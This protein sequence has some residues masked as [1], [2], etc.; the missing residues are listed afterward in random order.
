MDGSKGRFGVL[1]SWLEIVWKHKWLV[2]AFGLLVMVTTVLLTRR[3]TKIYEATAQLVID[4]SAPQYLPQHGTEVVSLGTA[5]SWNTREFFE[6]Q[7]RIIK[8]RR[9]AQL[10]VDKL[11]L[12]RDLD[13]L[14]LSGIADPEE[15]ARQ[16][17]SADAVGVLI[18]RVKV[19]PVSNSHVVLISVRDP[20]PKR[21]A[22]L[23]DEVS[24]AYASLN[25]GRKVSAATEAVEWLK[26]QAASLAA[27]RDTAEAELLSFKKDKGIL[28]ASLA[29]KQNLI[30]LNLQDA[31]RQ[32]R[33]AR[34]ET[35][36][37]K[38]VLDQVGQLK[39]VDAANNIEAVLNNGLIQ[40]LKEQLVALQNERDELLKRYLEKHPDVTVADQKIQR[41]RE[42]I[43]REVEG[44]RKS[45]RNEHEQALKAERQL[46]GEVDDLEG[47]ARLMHANEET[48]KRLELAVEQKK[49]L[50]AQLLGRLKEA[51]MQADARANNVRVLDE[52]L[53]PGSPAHPR[54]LLN[55]AIA[56]LV[57]LLGGIG[58]AFLVDQLDST[59]KNQDQLEH[60]FGLTFLGIIPSIRNA[61]LKGKDGTPLNPDR[62][63]LDNPRSTVAECV[64][65]IRTNLL[66]MAPERELR[67][68][69]ITSAGPREGKTCTC[70]NIGATMA[71]SGSRVLL[72][73]SD[74]RRPRLHKIFD[75]KN[76]RGLTDL[77][78]NPD[79]DVAGLV[80]ASGV[81]GMDVLCT[82][83][84]PPNP[85][86]LIHTL[87]FRRALDRLLEVYD[88]VIFDS[89]PVV[90][91][92]DAQ[93]LSTLVDGTLLVVRAGTTTRPM[94]AKAVRLL[95]DVN[96]NLLGGLLNNLDVTRRGYGHYYYQYYGQRAYGADEAPEST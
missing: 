30:G 95:R 53:V 13:F 74:L 23:A 96:G 9:V 77:V 40:R 46:Q 11:G 85:A 17:E 56:A 35:A 44:V 72:I 70:V 60:E 28:S 18:G 31:Q 64:R 89:P 92:T 26:Q 29:D 27:E 2:V 65:T 49:A 36:R 91:V 52:A 82:G 84:L 16:L 42:A 50:H 8:S 90:A 51:E 6:T 54:L 94:L 14:G 73:D 59:V 62:Y 24:Y 12:D 80:K 25:V 41:V 32:L 37:V 55:L 75:M 15:R 93:I 34:R 76:D 1:G 19:Q 7:Y 61:R 10:V 81:E 22:R 39:S 48:Y 83:P 4:L 66:F 33:E 58:L 57:A 69:L 38:A 3:Q 86:E 71:M 20:D 43:G 21:A 5:T 88:R 87:G 67:S 68:M 78:M 63:V 45:I 79:R 47:Q